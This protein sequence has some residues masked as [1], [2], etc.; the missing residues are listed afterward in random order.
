MVRTIVKAGIVTVGLMAIA[1]LTNPTRKDYRDY[2]V[3]K[4][5]RQAD[6]PPA[7]QAACTTIRALPRPSGQ[8]V[9]DQYVRR[10]NY[11]L[12]S[13]YLVDSPLVRDV[14]LGVGGHFIELESSLPRDAEAGEINLSS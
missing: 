12:F 13:I 3:Y 8:W 4:T 9:V 10:R 5:C 6:R 7:V 1:I 2:V 11:W 14:S